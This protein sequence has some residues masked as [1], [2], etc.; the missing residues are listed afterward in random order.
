M[1]D[2]TE[3][4][5]GLR[6]RCDH[7]GCQMAPIWVPQVWVPEPG[8]VEIDTTKHGIKKYM[9]LHFCDAH[10]HDFD[11]DDIL[12]DRVKAAFEVLA[13]SRWGS[14]K[15]EF[16]KGWVIFVNV[17]D[18]DYAAYIANNWPS[19]VPTARS[20]IA[21]VTQRPSAPHA[22]RRRLFHA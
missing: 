14:R 17:R 13:L 10:K 16:D 18:P 11:Y 22:T 9:P 1:S 3:L 15:L 5:P 21:Q 6:I 12:T 4:M 7:T 19:L 20:H 8:W 2:T